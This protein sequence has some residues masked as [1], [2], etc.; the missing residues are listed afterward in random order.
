M[1]EKPKM[2]YHIA[3][4]PRGTLGYSSK[5]TEEL[6]ELIDA[7]CQGSKV[8]ALCEL[9]DMVGAIEMY[10]EKN[11]PGLAFDELVKMAHLTRRAFESGSRR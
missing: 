1:S 8:L 5:I 9:A 3:E 10:L 6:A 2:G 7:E 4:I 11:F